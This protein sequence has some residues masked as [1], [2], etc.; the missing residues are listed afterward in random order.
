M[1]E[2]YGPHIE[3]IET[4]AAGWAWRCHLCDLTTASLDKDEAH[5][6]ARTHELNEWHRRNSWR[7]SRA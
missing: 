3:V 6:Q 4:Y 1:G 5:K 2:H 7:T